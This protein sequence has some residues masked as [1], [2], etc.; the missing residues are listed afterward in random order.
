[1][2]R[3][4]IITLTSAALCFTAVTSY[5]DHE[6]DCKD[7]KHGT[8]T[9]KTDNSITV[10]GKTYSTTS[11]TISRE[12][13]TGAADTVSVGDK[14]CIMTSGDEKSASKIVV[15]H[16]DA[17]TDAQ[18]SPTSSSGA[19]KSGYT[20]MSDVERQA[21]EKMCKGHH[22]T[23][24]DKTA[25]TVTIDGKT[26]ALKIN[27]PVNK[28]EEAL[29]PKISK[30]GDRVCF[31]TMKAA[32]GSEQISALMGVD[33]ETDRVRVRASDTDTEIKV[34]N[35]NGSPSKLEVE[36]PNKKIEVK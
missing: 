7:G 27:T 15:M 34:K 19:E 5:A 33:Q 2:K 3:T 26:Y 30:V 36:T 9:A 29:I 25:Q 23:I 31:D 21:H 35:D 16:K 32:D 22:G 1:M 12:G 18:G 6:K 8:V 28:Q 14:V 24:T 13:T 17:K 11:A 20:H 4:L 10:G